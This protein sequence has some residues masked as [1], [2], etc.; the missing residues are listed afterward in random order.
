M[1]KL[2]QQKMTNA[3]KRAKQVRP[4]VKWLGERRFSVT[5]SDK[6]TRYTVSFVVVNGH[7]LAECDC[8]AGRD[9]MLCFHVAAAA[10]V[11]I[12]VQSTR[13]QAEVSAKTERPIYR[14]PSNDL[15]EMYNGFQI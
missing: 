13:R 15:G 5:S 4:F 14:R 11:N 1:I 9:G 10:A 2:E 7:K 6:L 3:I 8:R 12:A